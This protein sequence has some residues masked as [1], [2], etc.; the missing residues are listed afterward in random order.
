[1]N[2]GQGKSILSGF[3]CNSAIGKIAEYGW[4]EIAPQMYLLVFQHV[5]LLSICCSR[6]FF[7]FK[8]CFLLTTIFIAIISLCEYNFEYHEFSFQRAIYR[9][10]NVLLKIQEHEKGEREKERDREKEVVRF[11]RHGK[12]ERLFTNAFYD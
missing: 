4:L 12:K 10:I 7:F 9:V 2:Y 3:Y 8:N 6:S 5:R 11:L 1:M